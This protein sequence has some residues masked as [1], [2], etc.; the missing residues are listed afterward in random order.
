MEPLPPRFTIVLAWLEEAFT[1]FATWL[2][3]RGGGLP[4]RLEEDRAS[5]TFW[6][7]TGVFNKAWMCLASA[8]AA[9]R[10]LSG[11]H[12]AMKLGLEAKEMGAICAGRAGTPAAACKKKAFEA[13]PVDPARVEPWGHLASW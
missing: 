8:G 5:C 11:L 6:R 7:V 12:A 1:I 2:E 13:S 3:R 10:G 4:F 9:V